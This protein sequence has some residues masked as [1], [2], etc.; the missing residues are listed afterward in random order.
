MGARSNRN[1]LKRESIFNGTKRACIEL[2][3]SDIGKELYLESFVRMW[4]EFISKQE[5]EEDSAYLE[6]YLSSILESMN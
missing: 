6:K 3:S 1:A 2:F 5:D 4:K